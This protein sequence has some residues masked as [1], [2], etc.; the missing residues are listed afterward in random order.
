MGCLYAI[1][2]GAVL[3]APPVH[4]QDADTDEARGA[5][6]AGE[7]AYR[8]GRFA[9]ALDYF[10]RAYELTHEPDLLYNIATVQDRLRHDREAIEAYR[11]YLDARPDSSDRANIEARVAILLQALAESE[12]EPGPRSPTE[13]AL[14][15]ASPQPTTAHL[16]IPSPGPA[17]SGAGPGPWIMVGGSAA[18]IVA[19]LILLIAGQADADTVSGG[20]RWAAIQDAFNRAPVLLSTGWVLLGLGAAAVAGGIAWAVLGGGRGEPSV[21]LGPGSVVVRGSF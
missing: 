3:A 19:G 7:A 11:A 13:E 1:L 6:Q 20:T 15:V 12:H 17:A 14:P 5:F 16:A 9:E 10:T 8:A 18:V 2:L 21:A 4:A